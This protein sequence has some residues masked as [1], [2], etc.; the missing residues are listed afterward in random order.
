[1]PEERCPRRAYLLRCWRHRETPGGE[2]THWRFSL[3][4][5]LQ[6]GPRRGF[7]SLEAVVSFLQ[8]ELDADEGVPSEEH[9]DGA[10]Q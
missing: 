4:E 5:V 8:G 7:G 3:E 9:T 10:H 6:K 2:G 1:M